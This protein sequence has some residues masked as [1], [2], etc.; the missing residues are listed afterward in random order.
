MVN[1]SDGQ[2]EEIKYI[3]KQLY[4][5]KILAGEGRKMIFSNEMELRQKHRS[6]DND[7]DL[8][9]QLFVDYL[10]VKKN[11]SYQFIDENSSCIN[12]L[13]S[14]RTKKYPFSSQIKEISWK[15]STTFTFATFEKTG[16][17]SY[18]STDDDRI[19][20]A[21]G[22]S[23]S[24]NRISFSSHVGFQIEFEVNGRKISLY[25]TDESGA[26]LVSAYRID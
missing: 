10:A 22:C 2:T 14:K 8:I 16:E 11:V 7:K 4:I 20:S 1:G 21:C 25:T 24:F 13:M 19:L 17:F 5:L 15:D 6:F 12:F 9:A 18:F 26:E 23:D 3:V